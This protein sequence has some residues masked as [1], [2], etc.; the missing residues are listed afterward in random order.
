MRAEEYPNSITDDN[1]VAKLDPPVV[2]GKTPMT[3]YPNKL[4]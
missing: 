3:L 4:D 2:A 1:N